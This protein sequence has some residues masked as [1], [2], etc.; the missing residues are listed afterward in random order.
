MLPPLEE[1]AD[2]SNC[3]PTRRNL[4]TVPEHLVLK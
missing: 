3:G 4:Y 2:N 1:G